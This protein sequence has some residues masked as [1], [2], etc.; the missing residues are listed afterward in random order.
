[1]TSAIAAFVTTNLEAIADEL[2]LEAYYTKNSDPLGYLADQ[3]R[4]LKLNQGYLMWGWSVDHVTRIAL[5]GQAVDLRDEITD[6]LNG[7]LYQ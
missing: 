5:G 3:T 7:V 4:T 6:A 1:M 2:N